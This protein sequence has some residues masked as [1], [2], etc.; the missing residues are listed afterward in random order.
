MIKSEV[1]EVTGMKCGGCEANVTGKLTALDGVISVVAVS[2]AN[3][4]TVEFDTDN[5]T[6]D[7]LEAVI[8]AA[9]FEVN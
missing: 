2:Q 3:E 7:Q 5:I 9:G 6:L 8:T 1:L 4:V